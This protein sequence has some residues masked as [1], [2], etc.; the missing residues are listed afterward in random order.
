M[1]WVE[2][3]SKQ[4]RGGVWHYS[5]LAHPV[6]FPHVSLGDTEEHLE[7]EEDEDIKRACEE[8]C[9]TWNRIDAC[10]AVFVLSHYVI[11]IY[12]CVCVYVICISNSVQCHSCM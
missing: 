6:A 8:D 1:Q 5:C 10:D 3:Q 11:C 4:V 9:V 2:V 12:I 7:D